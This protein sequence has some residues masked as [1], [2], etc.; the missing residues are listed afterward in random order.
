MNRLISTKAIV[1]AATLVALL[2]PF[3][4]EG[5]DGIPRAPGGEL[6]TTTTESLLLETRLALF[7]PSLHSRAGRE[8]ERIVSS[9]LTRLPSNARSRGW[10]ELGLHARSGE[11]PGM[12]I[13][14]PFG[15]AYYRLAE[16]IYVTV[17]MGAVGELVFEGSDSFRADGYLGNPYLGFGFDLPIEGLEVQ[18]LGG[19]TIPLAGV[20]GGPAYGFA[21]GIRGGWSPWLWASRRLSLVAGAKFDL[22]GE[23]PLRFGGEVGLAPMFWFGEGSLP[24][25]FALQGALHGSL[26]IADILDVGGRALVVQPGGGGDAQAAAEVFANVM[27]S[28]QKVYHARLTMPLNRPYGFAFSEGGFWGL[29]LGA[30][31]VF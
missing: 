21:Q 22:D 20:D 5:S 8:I 11:G 3:E 25:R 30:G 18:L 26:V 9:P 10:A 16:P 27:G 19:F 7:Q 15:A 31:M 1:L 4:T 6:S 28:G 29:H 2:T 24:A 14:S 12:F 13:A 23:G 17:A